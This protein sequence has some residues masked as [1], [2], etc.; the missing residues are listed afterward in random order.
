M[1]SARSLLATTSQWMGCSWFHPRRVARLT[2]N[3]A[4]ISSSWL[5]SLSRTASPIRGGPVERLQKRVFTTRI[6][7]VCVAHERTPAVGQLLASHVE[8][9]LT[10]ATSH[11][12]VGGR[13]VG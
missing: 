4:R 11:R 1:P 6:Q 12:D 3:R 7:K 2:C 10:Q 8:L 9:H 13:D 5:S